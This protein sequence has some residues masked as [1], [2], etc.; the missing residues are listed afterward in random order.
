M[1]TTTSNLTFSSMYKMKT[2]TVIARKNKKWSTNK[3]VI[4]VAYMAE[5][6]EYTMHRDTKDITTIWHSY[7]LYRGKTEK[8]EE[9]RMMRMVTEM[10]KLANFAK[11]ENKTLKA[12][13]DKKESELL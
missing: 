12:E 8:C 7:P 2:T 11:W 1:T 10:V 4:Q 6:K 3:T 13:L 9:Q 5:N